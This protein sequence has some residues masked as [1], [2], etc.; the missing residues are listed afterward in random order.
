VPR[1]HLR[2]TAG[3]RD[4]HR[5]LQSGEAAHL[6]Y[7]EGLAHRVHSPRGGQDALQLLRGQSVDLQVEVLHGQAQERIAHDSPHEEG[8]PS[9]RAQALEEAP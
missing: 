7:G 8:S 2:V 4:V 9:G 1:P 5:G 6:V 3:K